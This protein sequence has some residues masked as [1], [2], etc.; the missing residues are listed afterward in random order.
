MTGEELHELFVSE[1]VSP[2][3]AQGLWRE[4]SPEEQQLF[5][6]VATRLIEKTK[7]E[8]EAQLYL[9]RVMITRIARCEECVHYAPAT[10]CDQ[11]VDLELSDTDTPPPDECPLRSR[12]ELLEVSDGDDGVRVDASFCR[13][14]V[15]KILERAKASY[16]E[17]IKAPYE[18]LHQMCNEREVAMED[19]EGHMANR[20]DTE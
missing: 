11:G 16:L 9:R 10:G 12:P 8:Q 3:D 6:D 5:D 13:R 17:Q 19:I 20:E 7:E 1:F 14:D 18:R 15:H 2:G 4:L